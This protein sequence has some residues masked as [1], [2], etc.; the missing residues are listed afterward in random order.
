M[1][2][3][4]CPHLH[5]LLAPLLFLLPPIQT[6]AAHP[7]PWPPKT[8]HC[9]PQLPLLLHGRSWC[10]QCVKTASSRSGRAAP[11]AAK[12]YGRSTG[13]HCPCHACCPSMLSSLRSADP[14]GTPGTT[15]W[16]SH[17]RAGCPPWQSR[18]WAQYPSRSPRWSRNPCS[19]G[20]A[21]R[22]CRQG[23]PGQCSV[24]L[25]RPGAPAASWSASQLC[26]RPW[27]DLQ[28]AG[29]NQGQHHS[30]QTQGVMGPAEE[31]AA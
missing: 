25:Q 27:N 8:R 28:H 16:R 13:Q 4:Q 17:P 10:V 6:A 2:S 12:C 30:G 20:P 19:S 26:R 1:P 11:Q 15:N 18:R 23:K 14:A 29:Q 22:S 21:P 7:S 9:C 5:P 24:H 31:P 3:P